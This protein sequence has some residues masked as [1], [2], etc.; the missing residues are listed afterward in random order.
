MI[1]A[2]RWPTDLSPGQFK[3]ITGLDRYPEYLDEFIK[4]SMLQVYSNG[5]MVYRIRGICAKISVTWNYQAPEGTG[6]SHYSAMKGKRCNLVIR[7]G[8]DE[9]YKPVLYIELTEKENTSVFLSDLRENFDKVELKYPGIKL[10]ELDKRKW[11]VEIPDKYKVSHE[12]HFGQVA[13]KY[14]EYLQQGSM[15]GWEVPNMITKYY[16]ITRALDMAIETDT[17]NRK[18]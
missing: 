8:K 13:E 14:L 10:I 5:E 16:T 15:P 6:D 9:Q 1:S 17:L 11:M 4:D 2:R 12:E 18:P 7:Q 3:N